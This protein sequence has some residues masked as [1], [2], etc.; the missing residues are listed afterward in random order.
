MPS[1]ISLF[2]VSAVLVC[3]STTTQAAVVPTVTLNNGVKM[4]VIALGTAG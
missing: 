2:M 4:P 1:Y 3:S